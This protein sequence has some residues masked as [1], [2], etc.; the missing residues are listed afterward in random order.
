MFNNKED[1]NVSVKD[2]ETIIGPSI[3]IKGNFH[4]QGNMIIEGIVEGSVKTMNRLLIR[5]KAKITASIEAKEVR[6][7]GEVQ[8]HIKVGGYLEITS[9]AKIFGDIETSEISIERGAI[10]NGKINMIKEVKNSE[11]KQ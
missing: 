9:T 11:K 6:V 8:G 3:K 4:G 7:G 1:V 2:A 5:D 10:I